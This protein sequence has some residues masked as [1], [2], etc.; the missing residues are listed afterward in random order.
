MRHRQVKDAPNQARPDATEAEKSAATATKAVSDAN[1][2]TAHRTRIH[3]ARRTGPHVVC[4]PRRPY[5]WSDVP[6]VT[7]CEMFKLFAHPGTAFWRH[8][9]PIRAF[10]SWWYGDGSKVKHPDVSHSVTL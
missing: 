2:P 4:R 5:A 9:R 8:V 6:L 1:P 3:H 10:A 7:T